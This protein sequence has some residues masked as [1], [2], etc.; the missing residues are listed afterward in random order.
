MVTAVVPESEFI[1]MVERHGVNK[2]AEILGVSSRSANLR[3]RNIERLRGVVIKVDNKR[4]PTKNVEPHPAR[5]EVSLE[6]GNVLIGS[7]SHYWPGVISVSHRAFVLFNRKYKPKIVIKNG[8]ELDFPLI[9]RFSPI[10]WEKRPQVVDE[11][12]HASERLDE[13]RKAN[14]NAK[15]LWPLGNHDGRYETR[16]A[17]QAPEYAKIK[18]VHLKDHFPG[19]QPCWSVWIN[20]NVVVKHRFRGGI[21]ATRNNTLHAGMSIITGHLHSQKISPYSDYKGTRWGVDA[22]TMADPYGPQFLDYTEDNP[23]DWRQGFCWL[24]FKDGAL[25]DPETVRV[26]DDNHVVFRGELVRV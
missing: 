14:P 3:R 19:W 16:L 17:T 18:G 11:I 4:S 23:K 20:G 1:E 15:Y 12:E 13:I 10:G 8:D 24:T 26:W 2:T 22:G 21:H 9:S 6:N 5:I 7:D 25:L